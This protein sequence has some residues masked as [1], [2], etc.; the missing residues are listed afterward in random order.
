[1]DIEKIKKNLKTRVFGN[2]HFEPSVDSTN[3]WAHR[4][5]GMRGDVFIADFQT[6]GK[7]RLERPW[8]S[9][10]GKNILISILD[11][12][13]APPGKS[14][15]LSLV[16]GVSFLEGLSKAAP[17]IPFRLKWPNDI[18]VMDKKLGGILT[19]TRKLVTVVGVGLNINTDS[20]D[21][22]P[23]VVRLATSLKILSG[24]DWSREE[25]IASCLNAYDLWR[26]KFRTEGMKPVIAA[27]N[28]HNDL[29]GKKVTVNDGQTSFSGRAEG[30]DAEGFLVVNVN[31]ENQTVI[32]GDVT[33]S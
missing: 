28:E 18:L 15:Q 29:V 5:G 26:E 10:A 9:P 14:F 11:A 21:F 6:G 12:T 25:I 2:L 23:D 22:S 1:M 13:P 4:S 17:Q 16:A 33:C 3:V 19:E 32:S 7:G 24:K 31:G 8:E 27:W 30:L 20:G